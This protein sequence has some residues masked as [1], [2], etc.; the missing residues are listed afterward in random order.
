[1]IKF[2]PPSEDE[3]KAFEEI[4]GYSVPKP[5]LDL[6]MEKGNGGFGP[7][8]GMLGFIEGHKTDL[9]D[10]IASLYGAFC[11]ADPEDPGWSWPRHLVP[12]IHIGCAVHFCFDARQEPYPVHQFDPNGYGPGVDWSG[13]FTL[14]CDSLE[15]WLNKNGC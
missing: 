7:D 10:S 13:A 6:Y 1:M 11:H 9:D 5:L 12:F 3:I 14:A 2:P 15:G 8:Y 4:I